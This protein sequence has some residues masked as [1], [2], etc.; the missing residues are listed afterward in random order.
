MAQFF[1]VNM[2]Y[3]QKLTRLISND[4]SPGGFGL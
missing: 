3:N 2:I 1:R 4:L